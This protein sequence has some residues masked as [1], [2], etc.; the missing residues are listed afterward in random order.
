[1]KL[2][3]DVLVAVLVTFCLTS[4]LF[5]VKPIGSQIQRQYDPWIDTNDDGKIDM[6]DVIKTISLFGTTGT[7]IN[8]TALLLE[9][10]SKIDNLNMSLNIRVPKK[11]YI[12]ISPAAFTPYTDTQT[13]LKGDSGLWGQGR[14]VVN[15]QLPN[16]ATLT[17]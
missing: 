3:R 14:F 6:K 8:K 10:L 16:G 17:K 2:R 1:M 13:Y 5:V 12:S 15:V 11:G 4:A 7:P 9:I